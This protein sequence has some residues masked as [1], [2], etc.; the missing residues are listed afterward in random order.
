M[1]Q[2]HELNKHGLHTDP[3]GPLHSK[4]TKAFYREC[5]MY[6]Y[7]KLKKECKTESVKEV[8]SITP[9]G[10]TP[11]QAAGASEAIRGKS[12]V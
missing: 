10:A 5:G 2:G 3:R 7:I 8:N 9:A 12:E 1:D 4:G 6:S 11:H